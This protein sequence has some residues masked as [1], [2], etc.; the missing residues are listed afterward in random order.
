MA[1]FD[2]T[3]F[4]W[5]VIQPLLPNKVRGVPHA[6]DRRRLNGIFGGYGRARLGRHSFALR[7]AYDLR[8][9]LQPLAQ[10]R[11]LGQAFAGCFKGL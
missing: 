8:E 5:S 9:P 1:R 10:G 2:L 7:P 4:E 6:D 11:G 3:D